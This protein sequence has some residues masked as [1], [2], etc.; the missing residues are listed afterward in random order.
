[1][2]DPTDPTDFDQ[3]DADDDDEYTVD[4][5]CVKDV[6]AWHRFVDAQ[7]PM[8]RA[9]AVSPEAAEIILRRWR[10]RYMGP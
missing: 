8:I 7:E 1:M 4:L 10:G 3:P 9:M 2:T 5:R 6:E